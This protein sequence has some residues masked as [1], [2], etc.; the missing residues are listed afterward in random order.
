MQSHLPRPGLDIK[1]SWRRMAKKSSNNGLLIALLHFL[2]SSQ[3][4]FQTLGVASFLLYEEIV[5]VYLKSLVGVATYAGYSFRAGARQDDK[6]N[7]SAVI[8][9]RARWR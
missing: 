8:M 6:R 9:V 2:L 1:Q 7:K 3:H 5:N 4:L